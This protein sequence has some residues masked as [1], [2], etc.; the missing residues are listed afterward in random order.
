MAWKFEAETGR[1]QMNI[2]RAHD[3]F[4]RVCGFFFAK[5]LF[6]KKTLA[7]ARIIVYN[8]QGMDSA[9]FR[10]CRQCFSM[11]RKGAVLAA[12]MVKYTYETNQGRQ[13]N[14]CKG[15]VFD[16]NLSVRNVESAAH[17]F[18]CQNVMRFAEFR[19]SNDFGQ[20]RRG[21]CGTCQ[22]RLFAPTRFD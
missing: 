10:F 4:V 6:R 17:R 7:F 5:A 20:Q 12:K 3:S 21:E 18:A 11:Q 19:P 13:S 15:R 22:N 2:R 14:R 1:R 9:F 8:I 16:V